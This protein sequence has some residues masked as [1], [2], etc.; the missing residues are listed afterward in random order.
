MRLSAYAFF[1]ILTATLAGCANPWVHDGY[2]GVLAENQFKR[3][4]LECDVKAG[5]M[6]PLDKHEQLAEYRLCMTEKGW[7]ERQFGEGLFQ[8]K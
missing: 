2:D 1:L 4:S 8:R 6:H 3:D 5:E 7:R